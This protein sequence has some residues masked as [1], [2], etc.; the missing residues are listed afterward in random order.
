MKPTPSNWTRFTSA[1]Y[2]QD[3]ARAIDWLCE[4]FGFEVRIKVL[5]PDG[6]VRH[7]ELTYG[8]GLVMVAQES[9][10]DQRSYMSSLRSPRSLGERGTQ[11]I[12]FY[13]D[14]A[15]AHCRHASAL[16]AEI[17]SPPT[18]TDYGAQYWSDRGYAARDPEG[19]IW[20]IAQRLRG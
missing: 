3:A 4:A 8:D 2:Y 1:V 5:D 12:M 16:G 11:A 9:A 19:H 15:D 6:R 18:T 13:V 14:D 17:V 20:W 10:S 7:S